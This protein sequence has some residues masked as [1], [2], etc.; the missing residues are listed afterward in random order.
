MAQ[1]WES[2]VF[3]VPVH[4]FGGLVPSNGGWECAQFRDLV[5]LVGGFFLLSVHLSGGCILSALTL[6]YKLISY[7]LL[8]K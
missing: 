5:P 6:G 7:L 2:A 1:G 3:R 4:A 8:K